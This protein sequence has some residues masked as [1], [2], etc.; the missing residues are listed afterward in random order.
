MIWSKRV[1]TR[2]PHK[3]WGC[4]REFPAGSSIRYNT[5]IVGDCWFSW[6]WCDV[7][8]SLWRELAWDGYD[9]G[10][11]FGEMCHGDREGW[12]AA[13]VE[14]EAEQREKVEHGK[15]S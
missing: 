9:G 2:K 4:A 5:R 8:D 7:C 1:T 3:C 14:V 11:D 6:Y 10:C 12:E 13:R 15:G